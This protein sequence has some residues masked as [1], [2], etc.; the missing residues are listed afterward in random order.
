MPATCVFELPSHAVELPSHKGF[1]VVMI[2]SAANKTVTACEKKSQNRFIVPHC[3]CKSG[4]L[5]LL[6]FVISKVGAQW[7]NSI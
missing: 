6:V 5:H 3:P 1:N 2:N 4:K 7:E